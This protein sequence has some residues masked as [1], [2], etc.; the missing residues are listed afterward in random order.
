VKVQTAPVGYRVSKMERLTGIDLLRHHYAD[1]QSKAEKVRKAGYVETKNDGSERVCFT[2]YYEA[3][4]PLVQWNQMIT[5]SKDESGSQR[6]RNVLSAAEKRCNHK[7]ADDE[8]IF[9]GESNCISIRHHGSSIAFLHHNQG[10]LT[11]FDT[12]RSKSTKER[13][14]RILMRFCGCQLYQRKNV[15]YVAHPVHGDI[16]FKDRMQLDFVSSIPR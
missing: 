7:K 2:A 11:L 12:V 1:H 5:F 8:V 4:L 16:L 10:Y 13:L 9:F 3:V 6:I 14:N 15:W